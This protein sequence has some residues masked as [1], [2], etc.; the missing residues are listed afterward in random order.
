VDADRFDAVVRSLTDRSTRRTT[1]GI[2]LGGVLGALGLAVSEARKKKKRKKKKCKKCSSCQTCKKGKCKPKPEGTA[3]SGGVCVAGTCACL[4]GFKPCQ[5]SCVPDC[6][7]DADCENGAV[8]AGGTCSCLSGFKVCG[9]ECIPEDDCCTDDDCDTDDPCLTGACN[10][11]SCEQNPAP[12]GTIC[13]DP[14]SRCQTGVCTDQCGSGE[15]CLGNGSCGK[16]CTQDNQ[17][18][19][20]GCTGEDGGDPVCR[21]VIPVAG[22]QALSTCGTTADCPPDTVCSPFCTPSRC[23]DLC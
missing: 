7:T 6:C 9:E 2:S 3:C 1:L 15:T 5:G 12:N 4:S 20:C 13:G 8:C 11:G 16:T 21:Q 14:C 18:P 23:I 19:L 10:Q 17:C 22:C